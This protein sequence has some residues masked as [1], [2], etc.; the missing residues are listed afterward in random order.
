M[1]ATIIAIAFAAACD[2]TRFVRVNV[3]WMDWPAHVEAGQPFRTRL[4]VEGTCVAKR[5]FG[6]GVKADQ[7]AVTFEPYF[8]TDDRPV[9]PI[10]V[11]E[12]E[13]IQPF[14]IPGVDTAGMAPGLAGDFRVYEMRASSLRPSLGFAEPSLPVRTFG[15]VVVA[16]RGSELTPAGWRNAAGF[17][18]KEIDA[19]GCVRIRPAGVGQQA[20]L[21]LENPTD[22]AGISNTFVRGYI[23]EVVTPLCGETT[24]F[25]MESRN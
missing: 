24:L 7:S 9:C 13:T 3:Q 14:S 15:Q 12:T 6:A 20:A 22:T 4:V 1:R 2:S 8:L 11:V 5:G 16:Q 19:A 21:V 25:H 23:H 17:A 10:S 18:Y